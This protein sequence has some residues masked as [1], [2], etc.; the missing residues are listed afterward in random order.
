MEIFLTSL[1]YGVYRGGLTEY[2]G[3]NP[4]NGFADRL[5][6]AWRS[7]SRVLFIASQPDD[8]EMVDLT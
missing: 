1:P 6:K 7:D 2:Y 8:Y 5:E 3:F 4:A